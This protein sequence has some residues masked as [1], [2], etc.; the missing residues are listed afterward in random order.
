MVKGTTGVGAGNPISARCAGCWQ[1]RL[2]FHPGG[3]GLG[4]GRWVRMRIGGSRARVYQEWGGGASFACYS[5]RDAS[6]SRWLAGRERGGAKCRETGTC[7]LSSRLPGT[8]CR[9]VV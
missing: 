5:E 8:Y 3:H 4:R 9:R 2:R 1:D 6:R 7:P